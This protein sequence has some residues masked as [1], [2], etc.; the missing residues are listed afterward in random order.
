MS[1][2]VLCCRELAGS[3]K[4]PSPFDRAVVLGWYDGPTDGLV[5][6]GDCKRVYRFEML[7]SV[8]ED[9]LIRGYSG[10]LDEILD[11]KPVSARSLGALAVH[12]RRG[13][14]LGSSDGSETES[15]PAW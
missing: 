7:D 10:L 11:V 5:R 8:D 6:C 3:S 2:E 4:R 13:N 12:P 9:G 1:G 15:R 14:R